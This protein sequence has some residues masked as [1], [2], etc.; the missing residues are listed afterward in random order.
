MLLASSMEY[1]ARNHPCLDSHF[2]S[3]NIFVTTQRTSSAS[4]KPASLPKPPPLLTLL[5]LSDT[6]MA[7]YGLRHLLECAL[8]QQGTMADK[9]AAGLSTAVPHTP[10]AGGLLSSQLRTGVL[11]ESDTISLS[12]C[13]AANDGRRLFPCGHRGFICV[14]EIERH[15]VAQWVYS[16]LIECV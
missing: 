3:T 2:K 1:I 14:K 12:V 16:S 9:C 7:V 4:Q 10:W 6:E 5:I 13:I 11:R 8:R 15:A